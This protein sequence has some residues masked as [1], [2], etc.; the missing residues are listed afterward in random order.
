M[1]RWFTV[2][3]EER[4]AI[5]FEQI[6]QANGSGLNTQNGVNDIVPLFHPLGLFGSCRASS[7]HINILPWSA[8]LSVLPFSV[9]TVSVVETCGFP[10]AQRPSSQEKPGWQEEQGGPSS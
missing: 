3:I 9:I 7:L 5:Y 10:E 2:I 8:V 1:V 4:P 6:C